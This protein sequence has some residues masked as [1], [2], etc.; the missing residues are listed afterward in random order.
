MTQHLFLCESGSESALRD[1]IL[2]EW[3]SVRV[4][5]PAPGYV[6]AVLPGDT[7]LPLHSPI[8]APHQ[9][10][11][12]PSLAWS[13]QALPMIE[14]LTAT[15]IQTWGE[16]LGARLI[17]ALEGHDRAWRWHLFSYA[18]VADAEFTPD[19]APLPESEGVER[20]FSKISPR[21]AGL[22]QEVVID[23]LKRKQKRLLKSLLEPAGTWQPGEVFIQVC[24]SANDYGWWSST[25][26]PE[27][28]FWQDCLSRFPAGIVQIPSDLQAP[29]RAFAK[30]AEALEHLDRNILPRQTCVDLGAS[31]GSWTWWAVKQ[32]AFVQAIDR[33]PLRNDLMRHERVEF[34]RGDAFKF[35]PPAPVDWLLCDVAAF[36]DKIY[37]LLAKWL[38]HRWCRSFVVTIKFRGGDD[39]PILSKFK[40]LLSG[41]GYDFLLRKLSANKNEVTAMGS[42]L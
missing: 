4:A 7:Q 3:S 26:E 19:A 41:S 14:R 16:L 39:Y 34:S 33:S 40:L 8:Y 21:R 1:E 42:L 23:Y 11:W 18:P 32:G 27:R 24:L 10:G 30:L 12:I 38:G 15:S 17:T 36:P 6:C 9:A 5:S 37:E 20:F 13:R 29:A 2:R 25:S 31:P 28:N 22:I 35:S